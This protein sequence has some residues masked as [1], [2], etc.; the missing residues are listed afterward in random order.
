VRAAHLNRETVGFALGN[1]LAHKFRSFLTVLGII[2]GIVTVILVASV[3]VGVRQNIVNLF[4][5]FGPDNI[6][7]F[8]LQGDPYTPRAKP[9]ELTRRP[10]KLEHADRLAEMCPSLKAVAAQVLVPDISGGRPV[11]AKYRNAENENILVQGCTW[12]FADVTNGELE[13]GRVYTREEELRRTKVCVVGSNV[14]QALFPAEDPVGKQIEVDSSL[15]QVVGVFEKRKGSF[16][17]ENRQD[18]V[19]MVPAQTVMT[20][21]PAADSVVL[22]AQAKPGLRDVA[23]REV[24]EGLRRLRGLKAGQENDFHA[25][26]ADLIIQQFDR[27]TAMIRLATVAISGLGLLVG[28]IGVMN[29]ML[30]SVTQR[31][32]EIGVR[33]AVGATRADI[34]WQFLLEATMLT[35]MGGIVGVLAALLLGFGIGYIV[36]NLPATPPLWAVL[37]GLGVSAGVGLV[38]GVWPAVKAA[39]LDP[40][41][42]L[43][44]E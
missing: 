23:L 37:T 21:Y 4:R 22:Y 16:F 15:Y 12:N 34:V 27:V 9:E 19:V 20:R 24:E 8:H 42:S 36:P 44:Y 2:V 17:G 1:I 7:V 31:T 29:I 6:F 32:R 25:S 18:N 11:T 28:G 30:M 33:K 10:I 41:E 13:L 35:A 26:T 39:R 40:V 3:L 5:E 38:F 14:A 43:H